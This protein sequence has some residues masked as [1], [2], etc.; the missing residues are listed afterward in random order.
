[1]QP[2]CGN[3]SSSSHRQ[4]TQMHL[5]L[6]LLP[7][8]VLESLGVSGELADTLAELVDGHCN[9]VEVETEEA[10]VVEVALLLNVEAGHVGCLE[11]LWDAVLAVVELLKETRLGKLLA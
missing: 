8:D 7:K 6:D 3:P 11:L 10:L 9:L 2:K 5:C 4:T 1:M